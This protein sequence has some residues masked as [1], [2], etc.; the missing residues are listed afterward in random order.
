MF[1]Q[2]ADD[3]AASSISRT[4]SDALWVVPVSQSIH[5]ICLAVLVTAALMINLRLLGVGA[6]GRSVSSL[7]STL[8][9]WMWAALLGCFVTG[10]VQTIVE[11]VRQFVT[12]IYWYKMLLIVVMTLLTVW[13]IR[14]VRS[15]QVLWDGADRPAI[16]RVFAVVS[17]LAWLTVITFGRFIAY[18]WAEYQ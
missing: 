15:H 2:L 13:L 1:R 7:V 11:P 8:A 18:V 16:A 14:T 12:P 10:A 3:I 9:P 6:R 17:S 5:I 4:L